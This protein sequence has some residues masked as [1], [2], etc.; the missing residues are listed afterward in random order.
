MR[1]TAGRNAPHV[2]ALTYFAEENGVDLRTV[3][4]D[5]QSRSAVHAAVQKVFE[6]NGH[7]DVVVHN[8]GR[9]TFGP[10][11]AFTP[12]QLLEVYDVNVVGTQ[13]VNRSVLPHL[14]VH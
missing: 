9:T 2:E 14:R 12:E 7:I 1:D 5:V 13:R 10:T 4:M 3:E 6:A 8:A 11:E